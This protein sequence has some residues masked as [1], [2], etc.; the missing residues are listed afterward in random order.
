LTFVPDECIAQFAKDAAHRASVN[1]NVG[2]IEVAERFVD[3]APDRLTNDPGVFGAIHSD[4]QPELERHVEARSARSG[5]VQLHAGQV[6][7]RISRGSNEGDYALQ[8]PLAEW[9]FK[10]SAGRK[11]ER[12]DA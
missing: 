9:N 2:A 5:A 1:I 10:R 6:V 3:T 7:N 8:A 4:R 11:S 12:A